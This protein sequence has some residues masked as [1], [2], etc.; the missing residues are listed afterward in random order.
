MN[1]MENIIIP[2]I[3]VLTPSLNQGEFI[4]QNIVSVL[5]Q[6]YP[7]FEHVVVDGGSTD[8]TV[9]IL[10]KYP[11]LKW[12]SEPDKGQSDALNK[13]FN[14]ATGDIIAWLN[15]DDLYTPG[16][17]SLIANEFGKYKD[18]T[19]IVLIGNAYAC[20][21]AGNITKIFIGNYDGF[22]NMINLVKMWGERLKMPQ[23]S[24]FFKKS[25]ISDYFLDETLHL[26]MDYDLW[27]RLAFICKFV[28]EEKVLSIMREYPDTKSMS[29]TAKQILETK[30]I[31]KV[32][33]SRSEQKNY[34]QSKNY[35][36]IIESLILFIKSLDLAKMRNVRSLIFIVKGLLNYPYSSIVF[37]KLIA[38]SL[39]NL[40]LGNNISQKMITLF[41]VGIRKLNKLPKNIHEI[42]LNR[43]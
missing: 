11:H 19:N 9:S 16:T 42:W 33:S 27:M 30:N 4:E 35:D 23:P 41:T 29:Q 8:D 26:A 20:D 10:K 24:I 12:I 2:K 28:K 18:M 43:I 1:E 39:V 21:R 22:E 40:F 13:A 7:N 14:I 6:D 25:I 32:Y 38:N 5:Y 37:H 31:S 3:S 34:I 36:K 17:F 15:A